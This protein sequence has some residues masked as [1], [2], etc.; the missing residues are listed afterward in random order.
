MIKLIASQGVVKKTELNYETL[1]NICTQIFRTGFKK[2]LKLKCIIHKSRTE[3]LSCIEKISR[4][5]YKISLDTKGD[6][7]KRYYIGTILHEL[8]H[9][10]QDEIFKF[11]IVAKFSTYN[12]Y[13]NSLEEKDAR[14]Q[15]RLTTEVMKIYDNYEKAQE[16]F[17]K[18]NLKELG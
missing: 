4:G 10:I 7:N 17:V 2:D 1:G 12:A 9:A 18:F 13:Y 8:R 5:R 6:T 11:R 3:G 14:K 15:E 16:K